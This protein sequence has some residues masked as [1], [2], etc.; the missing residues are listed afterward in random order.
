MFSVMIL[1]GMAVGG[2]YD[3]LQ[4][5]Q[6]AVSLLPHGWRRTIADLMFWSLATVIVAITLLIGN[7]GDLRGYV[8]AGQAA[9]LALYFGLASPV[10]RPAWEK[11]LLW[12]GKVLRTFVV[13]L[14]NLIAPVI[15]L[16]VY[17]FQLVWQ[18]LTMLFTPLI[19][20]FEQTYGRRLSIGLRRRL[21]PGGRRMC[22]TLVQPFAQFFHSRQE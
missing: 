12:T 3:F 11:L 9:G 18:L 10:L 1:A 4:A 19:Q 7:W 13:L 20:R 17:P 14:W 8:F 16:M 2:L 6:A 22:Q 5:A 21:G 15:H